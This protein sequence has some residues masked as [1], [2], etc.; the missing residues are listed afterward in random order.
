MN[1]Q[2]K[3]ALG[4]LFIILL[5]VLIWRLVGGESSKELQNNEDQVNNKIDVIDVAMNLY[6]PW[7][8]ARNSTSTEINLLSILDNAPLTEELRER[9]KKEAEQAMVEM[10]PVI[11]QSELPQRIGAKVVYSEDTSAQL[12]VVPRGNRVPEQALVTLQLVDNVWLISEV[13]C[14]RGELAPEQE[15]S[16]QSE[17]FILR[18][19]LQPPLDSSV[20]HLIYSRDEVSGYT[21]PLF[22]DESSVCILNGEV[23]CNVD[24]LTEATPVFLQG[25]MQEAGVL[26]QRMEIRQ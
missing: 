7:L 17:G 6:K 9:L 16:F 24:Q 10:D 13:A 21:I 15:Y 4:L 22:F 19:S 2:I 26:V 14:S 18:D 25:A 12:I 1:K 3:I 11:C 20:W 8:D 23:V 5:G